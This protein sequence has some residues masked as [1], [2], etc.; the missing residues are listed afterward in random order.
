MVKRI[1]LGFITGLLVISIAFVGIMEITGNGLFSG[2]KANPVAGMALMFTMPIFTAVSRNERTANCNANRREIVSQI[3]NYC[4]SS[5]VTDNG[6]IEV[7]S[8]EDSAYDVWSDMYYLDEYTF[9]LLFQE[10]PYCPD[11]GTYEINVDCYSDYE[12][13]YPINVDVYCTCHG[14]YY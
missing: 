6:T 13:D 9:G 3:T 14:E 1:L 12:D 4:M 5:N 8:D 11:G 10:I 2:K 7:Y